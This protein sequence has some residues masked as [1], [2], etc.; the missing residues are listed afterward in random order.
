MVILDVP[1][2]ETPLIFL[3][4][5]NLVAEPALPDKLPVTSPVKL[6]V[7][8]EEVTVLNPDNVLELAP[9]SILVEP[10]VKELFANLLLAIAVPLQVPP[11]TLPVKLIS[12]LK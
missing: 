12:P 5:D 9:N 2:N 4:V 8:F 7:K 10:I 11:F 3:A 6:P 1:S